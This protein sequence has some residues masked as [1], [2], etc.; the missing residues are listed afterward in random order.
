M[1]ILQIPSLILPVAQPLGPASQEVVNN[2]L[3][4]ISIECPEVEQLQEKEIQILATEVVA[5]GVPGPLWI[6]V[7]LSPYLTTTTGVY[8]AAIGGGG[9]PVAPLAP[10]I[11][12]PTGVLGA[13][14]TAILPWNIH[15]AVARVVVQMPVAATPATAYWSVQVLIQGKA[16]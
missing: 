10:L 3:T 1:A 16:Q 4:H 14:Q 2:L 13:M 9:G 15:S 5:L 7:E 8:W 6:W 11:L 12:A